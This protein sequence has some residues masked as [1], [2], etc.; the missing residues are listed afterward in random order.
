MSDDRE[1]QIA[2]GAQIY[3]CEQQSGDTLFDLTCHSLVPVAKP[4]HFSEPYAQSG[5][6]DCHSQGRI[7]TLSLGCTI[8]PHSSTVLAGHVCNQ[9]GLADSRLADDVQVGAAVGVLDARY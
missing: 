1:R 9:R 4:E 6:T 3:K 2:A 7:R 8:S 5:T